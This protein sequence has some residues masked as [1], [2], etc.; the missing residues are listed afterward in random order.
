VKS[1]W[2]DSRRC[3]TRNGNDWADRFP[4]LVEA[5]A[6]LKAQSFLIDGEVVIARDDRTPGGSTLVQRAISFQRQWKQG[7]LSPAAGHHQ[8]EGQ[9]RAGGIDR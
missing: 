7:C 8:T 6:R 5:A 9:F 2:E 3:F 1:R 4:V